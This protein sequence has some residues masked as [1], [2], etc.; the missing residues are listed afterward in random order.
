MKFGSTI[1]YANRV[2]ENNAIVD[3]FNEPKSI[4]LRPNYFTV[5]PATTRGYA[6]VM[7]YGEAVFKTWTAI[8]NARAFEGEIKAGDV[9]YIDG[10]APDEELE[11]QYGFGTT[12]NAVV[13]NVAIGNLT[14][15]IKL[16]VNQSQVKQ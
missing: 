3:K 7:K 11:A 8:A 9:F 4:I 5:M 16:E 10:H 12:A 13:K 6:E 15:S 1:W 2:I 14:I